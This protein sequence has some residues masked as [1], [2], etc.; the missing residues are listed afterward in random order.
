MQDSKW[1]KAMFE[2]IRALVKNDT[3]DM[4][5]RPS[6][7]NKVGC[8]W[9]YSTKHTPEG[10]INTFKA[11]LVAKGYTQTYGVDY[12]ETFAPVAKMNIV[13]TLI[14][15]AVNLGWDLF[16]LDVKNAFLYGDL[17]EEVFMEIPPGFGN[18]RLNGKVCRLK[19][20]LYELK[21]SSRT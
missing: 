1:K 15:C 16:Q 8:K 4:V 12:E 20:S 2:E 17:K 10:K 11:R 13:I 21:Q 3:W 18:E 6:N 9:I 5:P 7:K 14:S 19:R